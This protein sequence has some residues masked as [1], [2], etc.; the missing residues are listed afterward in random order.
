MAITTHLVGIVGAL[1]GIS[2]QDT[3]IGFKWTSTFNGTTG[4]IAVKNSTLPVD[5]GSGTGGI[6]IISE[7]NVT[8]YQY[9]G[10]VV[11]TV[12]GVPVGVDTTPPVI[13]VS[14]NP[15]MLW[16]PN[17]KMVPVTVSGTITDNE[18]GATGVNPD[19]AVCTVTDEYGQVQPH[20]S[21]PLQPN[22]TYFFVIQLQ[23]SRAGND[24]D[25]RHYI[26]TVGVQDNAGNS[27]SAATGV[28][29]PHDQGH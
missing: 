29:V 8:N 14:A 27:G 2:V 3:G 25:G 6:T 10:I 24:R 1:P 22:G 20:G 7:Q 15:S 28:I 16:P 11:T 23:A 18:P 26:I 17:G 19:T 21:V 12:N 9:N 5:P 4:G 13:T